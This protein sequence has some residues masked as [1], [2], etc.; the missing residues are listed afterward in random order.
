MEPEMYIVK[1]HERIR[2]IKKI[3]HFSQKDF[4]DQINISRSN[5]GNIETKS[6]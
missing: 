3:L 5:P 1:A 6:T 4:A 2:D